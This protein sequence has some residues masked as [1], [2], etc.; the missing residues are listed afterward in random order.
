MTDASSS[1]HCD[2]CVVGG[3]PGGA[4]A[5]IYAA[6]AGLSVTVLEKEQFPRYH[7]GESLT[8]VAGDILRDLGL[9]DA[10]AAQRFPVKSGV[11]VM[12]RSGNE[13]FVPVLAETWQVRRDDF[14]QL[15]LEHARACGVAV[16][17]GH[18][19]KVVMNGKQVEGVVFHDEQTGGART[20]HC[21]A[22]IDA[23]GTAC[24]L[25]HAGVAGPR[26]FDIFGDQIAVFS[27]VE[28]A[29]RDPGEMGDNT[30]IFYS[31]SHT[32]AWF[33]PLSADVVSIG[34]VVPTSAFHELGKD[35]DKVFS[36][37]LEAIHPDLTARIQG[38]P[39]VEPV[40][41]IKDYSYRIAPFAGPGW[42]CIGDA[43][44]F[45]DPIFSFGVSS[46]MQ[47]AK[48]VVSA[49]C[50]ALQT[51]DWAT[52]AARYTQHSNTGQDAIFDFIR[53][54]WSY[55]GFFG[56]QMRGKFRK[57]VIRLFGGDIFVPN[58]I[59]DEIRTLMTQAEAPAAPI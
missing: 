14:D 42:F 29:I 51:A 15:L 35:R 48:A 46:S 44:R 57:E 32:W 17:R 6:R 18:A 25:S 56:L 37:G 26:K 54:F 11:K 2:V 19:R 40:R 23:S 41:A 53:Y 50:E 30:F 12:G 43:H 20:I 49:I 38:K 31:K 9:G 8:G 13:Y 47:E 4:T 52:V 24:F 33:I 45:A 27:Q 55:P 59:V 21:R 1:I 10:M 5:A 39:L 34:V 16:I 3:G 22:L 36:W 58:K 7:I 28:G